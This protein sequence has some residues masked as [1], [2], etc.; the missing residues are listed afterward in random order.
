L[1]SDSGEAIFIQWKQNG[2]A[3]SRAAQ[4]DWMTGSPPNESL[5]ANT[6]T[7]SGQVNGSTI[8]LSFSGDT[9]EFSTITGGSFTLNFP[10]P[11]GGF[12]PVR[13]QRSS[14][15]AFNSAVAA[16]NASIT[17]INTTTGE[18]ALIAKEKNAING[19]TAAVEGDI[20]ALNELSFTP[21]FQPL[22]GQLQKEQT[23]LA[24][25]ASQAKS[26][27]GESGNYNQCNDADTA[28]VDADKVQD[29]ADQIADTAD[30]VESA[31]RS[32]YAAVG[33][34][35]QDLAQL[36]ADEANL[37]SYTPPALSR[38]AFDDAI[39]SAQG[40]IATAMTTMNGRIDEANTYD[41]TAY[42]DAAAALASGSCGPPAP[43]PVA[44]GHI[45]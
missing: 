16:L 35:S 25:T 22:S 21:A 6:I 28:Q 5:S 27:E 12:A 26:A 17:Q 32:G 38:A 40:V 8:S 43:G 15:S 9:E 7:V 42:Q 31:V 10:Q 44:I 1:S 36:Q 14:T 29:D 11:D 45:S 19:E 4:D 3:V 13:F 2:A 37:P 20:N 24:T 41:S 34:A 30:G 33:Q 23:D 39:S 18:Q